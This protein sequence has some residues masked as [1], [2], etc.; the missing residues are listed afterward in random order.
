MTQTKFLATLCLSIGSLCFAQDGLVNS[1][2]NNKS[3]NPDFQ[4]TTIKENGVTSVKDQGSSGTCW[5]YSGNSFLE[6]EMIRMGKQ[7]VD[8]AEIFTA[9]NSYHDKAKLYVLNGGAISWGDGGEL[10]DVINMYRKY[11]AVP[12]EAYTGLQ[13]GQTRNNFAEMQ[14]VIKSMLDAYVKNPGK[15]LSA[16][17]LSNVD[18]ILDSYLGKYPSSFTY[19]GKQYTPKTFA[20]E[21]VGIVPEDY[22]EL[23]SYKDYPYYQKF[24]VPI[25]DNWSHEAIWNVPMEDLTTIIDNAIKNGYTVGWATDVSE[26]YFSYANGVAY[27]PN[28]D[29]DNMNSATRKELFNG[30]KA[31][32]TIT[33]DMR[34]E[35]INN[36]TT[37]DDHGMQIVGLAKDQNGKEYYMVKNSWGA[38]N[39]FAGYIYVTKPYVQYKTTG[40]LL[41]KDGIPKNILRKLKV[42]TNI[43]L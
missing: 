35:A 28:L 32:K 39:D 18:A 42:N 36:L 8:L 25:P 34:Q 12:Q 27:V 11:G 40:I 31:D 6:S 26:P 33:E 5:S 41:H 2:K 37:T 20:K 38:T 29:L 3:E 9:R 1:L 16:N 10:H 24:V 14:A 21:V 7:P 17:W 13:D 22:V 15:K 43:G 4:F 19:K 23:T 30:P